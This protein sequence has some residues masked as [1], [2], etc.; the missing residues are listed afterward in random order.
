M[1]HTVESEAHAA[2]PSRRRFGILALELV[3]LA[4]VVPL[5]L[6]VGAGDLGDPGLR[7]TLLEL[8]ALRFSASFLVGVA[9]AT[10]G[11]VVQGLFR[12][13][14]ADPSVL[15]TTSGAVLGGKAA[16]LGIEV[17]VGSAWLTGGAAHLAVPLGAMVG[18]AVSLGVL[19]ALTRGR[20]SLL[21]QLLVGFTLASLFASFGSVLTS[22]AQ[23]KWE[24]GRALLAF[25][26]GSVSGTSLAPVLFAAPFVV[27]GFVASLA[28]APSLD[29]LL[30]G[31]DEA[32]SLGVDVAF[33]RRWSA[34][35][36]AVLTAAAVSVS[37]F[38]GFVGLIVPHALRP[39]VGAAHARLL[40]H[41]AF[42]G[43]LFVVVCDIVSRAT[44]TVAEMPLGVVTGL[45]G[46]PLYL[47]LVVRAQRRGDVDA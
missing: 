21:A 27:A 44:P 39:I 13:P 9:L 24:L 22:I 14:L 19:F 32:R 15:G 25:S 16:L 34:L 3:A 35:W 26:L 40:P 5:A 8:R 43:G 38:V 4:L 46:A 47:R 31:E 7:S 36:I 6:L 17:A 45:V 2:D 33:V 10:S 29:L 1:S 30:G 37:G 12:N 18:A 42:V 23:R 11:V 20:R 28:L 41:A